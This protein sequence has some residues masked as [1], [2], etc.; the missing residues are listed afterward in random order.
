MLDGTSDEQHGAMAPHSPGAVLTPP[1][2]AAYR[3]QGWVL[4]RGFVATEDVA[5]LGRWSDE[6]ATRAEEQGKHM[7]YR[8][9]SLFD[10]ERRV[11]QRIE[12]FCPYH[13]PFDA[14]IRR[15]RVA[16]AVDQLFGAKACL[17]K[18]KINFKMPGGA[19]F[20]PHQDQQA[21]WS[22][23]APLFVT[24]LVTIDRATVENGCLEMGV[25]ARLDRLVGDEWRPL[26]QAEMKG[27]KL[28]P[29]PTEAGDVLFFD[30]FA[31][32][33]SKPNMT[34]RPRRILYLTYNAAAEGDH[35]QRY[36]AE[37]RANFPPDIERK[38]GVEYKFRV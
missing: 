30:S 28:V 5:A 13:A 8:E 12:N 15:G 24:A 27:F 11:I 36:F 1:Q 22:R 33:A 29:V 16:R 21:G 25:G 35:R 2:V 4:A 17:F 34:D 6:L 37:K 3:K 14:F 31:A 7:V 26:R 38:A 20:E 32:H 19:G 9:P 23:Y 10:K 18:E